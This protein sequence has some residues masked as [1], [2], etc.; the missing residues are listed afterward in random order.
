M[1]LPLAFHP[2]RKTSTNSLADVKR[3]YKPLISPRPRPTSPLSTAI[4]Y[5]PTHPLSMTVTPIC[6]RRQCGPLI[7]LAVNGNYRG[8]GKTFVFFNL[9]GS[10]T[11]GI[12]VVDVLRGNL[13][14]LIGRDDA[15]EL[16]PNADSM[17]LR[18]EVSNP[19]TLKPSPKLICVGSSMTT[20]RS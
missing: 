17:R 10:Q 11:C 16:N 15:V 9:T 5:H 8:D 18:I 12:R 1:L 3:G 20:C 13:E 19:P 2:Q 14:G 4:T 7:P 6:C